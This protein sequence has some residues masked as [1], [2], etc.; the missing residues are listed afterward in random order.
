M[1]LNPV[2]RGAY[3]G[4]STVINAANVSELYGV[5]P[6]D[7]VAALDALYPESLTDTIRERRALEEERDFLRALSESALK[8]VG[9]IATC[10]GQDMARS[11]LPAVID[12]V[13]KKFAAIDGSCANMIVP[14]ELLTWLLL[15]VTALDSR[16]I[17]VGC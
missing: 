4:R 13:D 9:P 7:P 2:F 3:L 14:A 17:C 6:T 1:Y 12:A 15:G 10:R 11:D 16:P 8:G 5:E